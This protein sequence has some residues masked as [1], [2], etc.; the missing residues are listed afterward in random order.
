MDMAKE[1]NAEEEEQQ[2]QQ[3]KTPEKEVTSPKPDS[4]PVETTPTQSRKTSEVM[5]FK[6][7]KVIE[8]GPIDKIKFR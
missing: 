7:V 4:T 5:D 6:V 8:Y 2:Q 1:T 3:Q